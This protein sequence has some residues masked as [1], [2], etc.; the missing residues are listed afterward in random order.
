MLTPIFA[1]KATDERLEVVEAQGVPAGQI[2]MGV[3][4]FDEPQLRHTGFVQSTDHYACSKRQLIGQSINLSRNPAALD[5]AA[6]DAGEHSDKVPA[7]LG[8]SADGFTVPGEAD[9]I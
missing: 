6:H 2:Y 3:E 7:D 5:A 4:M 1:T 8:F 9:V